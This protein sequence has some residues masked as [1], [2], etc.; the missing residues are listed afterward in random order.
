MTDALKLAEQQLLAP[1]GLDHTQLER[2]LAD[3]MGIETDQIGR[4]AA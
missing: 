4:E 2:V 1:G 3:L